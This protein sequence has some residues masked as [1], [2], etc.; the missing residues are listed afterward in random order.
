M[1]V[2]KLTLSEDFKKKTTKKLST[3]RKGELMWKK[4]EEADKSGQL[5]L[6]S[7]RAQL[8]ELVGITDRKKGYTWASNM[9]H[10]GA[11]TETFRGFR[12]GK[13]LYEFHLGK[14]PKYA[15]NGGKKKVEAPVVENYFELE[16]RMKKPE[17]KPEVRVESQFNLTASNDVTIMIGNITIKVTGADI[18]YIAK[19]VKKLCE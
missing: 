13:A 11:I 12:D 2:S 5:Q 10:R 6:C 3:V 4:L 15:H 1:E 18:E 7:R 14:K 17:E 16:E 19:L 9:L 8:G